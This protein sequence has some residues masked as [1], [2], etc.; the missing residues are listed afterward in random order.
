MKYT[1]KNTAI[2]AFFSIA[3][4]ISAQAANKDINT[5]LP[6]SIPVMDSPS[7]EAPKKVEVEK[8]YTPTQKASIVNLKIEN[9][10]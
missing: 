1:I 7:P 2:I 6:A 5:H 4:G 3:L 8:Q 9:L 10:K